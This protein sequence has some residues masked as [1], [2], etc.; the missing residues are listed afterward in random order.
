MYVC[1]STFMYV[2]ASYAYLVPL[3]ARS[4]HLISTTPLWELKLKVNVSNHAGEGP[5]TYSAIATSDLNHYAML[6]VIHLFKKN[7]FSIYSE[8]YELLQ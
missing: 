1:V 3:E 4:L 8:T 2:H 5:K 7:I 6:R